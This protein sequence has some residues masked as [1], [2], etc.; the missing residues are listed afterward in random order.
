MHNKAYVKMTQRRFENIESGHGIS[1]IYIVLTIYISL[2]C[3]SSDGYPMATTTTA[4]TTNHGLTNSFVAFPFMI[5][6]VC[7]A[8]RII[9]RFFL[10]STLDNTNLYV[11]RA[12]F[13]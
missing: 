12:F 13:S 10:L 4:T 2:R 11:N 3:I 8:Q 9:L 7:A 6:I 1:T 5:N